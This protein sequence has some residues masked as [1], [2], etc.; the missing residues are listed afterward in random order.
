MSG[1]PNTTFSRCLTDEWWRAGLVH[2]VLSPGSRSAPMALALA[3]HPGVNLHVNEDERSASF[4]A[5]GLAKASGRPVALLCTSGTA[6]ANFHPAVLEAHHASVPLLVCTADRPPELRG[7]GAPQT[8]D[9]AHLFGGATHW[10]AEPE[11]PAVGQQPSTWRSLAAR[12][13]A[14]AQGPPA[15][16]VHL[17]LPFREPLVPDGGDRPPFELG[18]RPDGRP[19]MAVDRGR[20]VDDE[21]VARLASRLEGMERGVLVSGFGA[22]L[23]P[24]GLDG[25]ARVTG[26]PTL[27]DPVSNLRS[28]PHTIST[29]DALARVESVATA[30]RPELVLRVGAPLTSKSAMS[31]LASAPTVVVDPRQSWADPEGVAD[32][33]VLG[34]AQAFVDTLA[35][36]I[37]APLINTGWR[38]EWE[39][40]ERKA[41]TAIDAVL[42]GWSTPFEGRIARDVMGALPEESALVVAS[43]MPIRDIESFAAPRDGVTVF[44]NRG[45]NGIDGFVSTSLGVA[46]ARPWS[47]TVALVGDLCFLHDSNGLSGAARSGVDTV[48]VVV[49]NNG[50]GVFSFL[51]Q[52][53][54]PEH[55]ETLFGTPVDMDLPRLANAY[56]VAHTAVEAADGLV[57][58]VADAVEAGGVRVVCVRT[59]RTDNVDRHRRV[60]AEVERAFTE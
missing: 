22:G 30:L 40:A 26:W 2:A 45:V 32:T 34:D 20:G 6:A 33:V 31:W 1:D 11:T 9:Q 43:S 59:D 48:F 18:G 51:P 15:G 16:P 28:G 17:N 57:P 24:G 39:S 41:R 42:D 7:V 35:E 19:W 29:Y 4:L 3:E 60:V 50:G 52:A 8:V 12:A 36:R 54:L 27:A 47:T 13:W 49:D 44:A 58:A 37:D 46:A 21:V 5:L 53:R 56:G 23:R 14:E 10:Y 25:L 55:F 38:R